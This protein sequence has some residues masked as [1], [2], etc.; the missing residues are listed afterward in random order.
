MDLGG[1]VGN[2]KGHGNNSLGGVGGNV[3]ETRSARWSNNGCSLHCAA[4][5]L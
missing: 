5:V 4:P 3:A 2:G 1:E